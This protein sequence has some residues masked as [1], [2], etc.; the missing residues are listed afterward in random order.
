MLSYTLV[1]PLLLACCLLLLNY[2]TRLLMAS[3]KL[4][5]SRKPSRI[6]QRSLPGSVWTV[7]GLF[8]VSTL[9]MREMLKRKIVMSTLRQPKDQRG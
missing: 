5:Y 4:L 9:P 1:T 2:P 6:A 7:D 3:I 8:V